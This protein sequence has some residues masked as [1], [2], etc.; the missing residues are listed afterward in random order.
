VYFVK[1]CVCCVSVVILFLFVVITTAKCRLLYSS[2]LPTICSSRHVELYRGSRSFS[3]FQTT[4]YSAVPLPEIH[5]DGDV[6]QTSLLHHRHHH[7]HH[8]ILDIPSTTTPRDHLSGLSSNAVVRNGRCPAVEVTE[9]DGPNQPRQR[10]RWR[11]GWAPRATV[12]LRAVENAFYPGSIVALLSTVALVLCID[13][14]AVTIGS[15]ARTFVDVD[16]FEALA[17]RGID[18]SVAAVNA[19]SDFLNA[20]LTSPLCVDRAD[21]DVLELTSLLH[22]RRLNIA[23]T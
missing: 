8:E 13:A 15:M 21:L 9:D 18:D 19:F 23:G 17:E 6:F 12:L 16:M 11:Q 3:A 14:T 1:Y 2:D 4:F 7:H 20:Q 5:A 10:Q 22:R